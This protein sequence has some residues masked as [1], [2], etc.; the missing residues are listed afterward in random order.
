M[1]LRRSVFESR[2]NE[3][4][5]FHFSEPF[6]VGV[7]QNR[8]EHNSSYDEEMDNPEIPHQMTTLLCMGSTC[9]TS[10]AVFLIMQLYFKFNLSKNAFIV[11]SA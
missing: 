8:T 7:C 10:D 9:S 3:L 11:C 5:P 4:Q 2:I 6:T 1:G